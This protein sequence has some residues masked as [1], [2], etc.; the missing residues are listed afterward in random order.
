MN[1]SDDEDKYP[2][3]FFSTDTSGEKKFEEFFVPGEDVDL[4]TFEQLGVIR[5]APS[6]DMEAIEELFE[7]LNKVFE[8]KEVTKKAIVDVMGDFIPNFK[9]VETGKSLDQQM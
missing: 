4:N 9:H 2:V 6:K 3:Y 7:A 8:S 5:N 1:L